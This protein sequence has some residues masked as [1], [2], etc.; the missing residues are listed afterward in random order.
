LYKQMGMTDLVAETADEYVDLA[1]RL[2]NDPAFRA[3]AV[4]K[5]E[6]RS[7]AI[8]ENLPAI[9]ELENFFASVTR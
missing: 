1:F 3:A 4:G 2:S 9:R 8:F 7:G 5:I 6:S